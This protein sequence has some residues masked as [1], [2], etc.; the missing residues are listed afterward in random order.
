MWIE[1]DLHTVAA[2]RRFHAAMVSGKREVLKVSFLKKTFYSA[3][4]V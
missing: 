2:N 4:M 1:S 3:A